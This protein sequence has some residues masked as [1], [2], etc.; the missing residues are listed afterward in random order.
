[1]IG[2][3]FFSAGPLLFAQ[4]SA[5]GSINIVFEH[6]VDTAVLQ[7]DTMVYHNALGQSYKVSNFKYYVSNFQLIKSNGEPGKSGGEIFLVRE[8]EAKSKSVSVSNIK[9]DTFTGMRFMIGVDSLYN[10]SGAQSG[11]LDPINGMFWAWNTG[12][13]FLKLEGTSP[14]STATGNIFEYHIGGYKYPSN[15]MRTVTIEFKTP[16]KITK[17]HISILKI[18]ADVS[19]IIKGPSTIDFSSLPVV[20]DQ[21]NANVIADNYLDIFSLKE[22]IQ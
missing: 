21:K 20:T 7:L 1:M 14:S 5:K 4:R 6:F 13:I 18:K 11:E 8:D 19:E 3:A 12:Y 17:D 22:I 16:L 2:L 9:E 15:C 10:C